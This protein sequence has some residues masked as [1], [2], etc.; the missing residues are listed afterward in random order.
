MAAPV[1]AIRDAVLF[2][3]AYLRV[4]VGRESS[5]RLVQETLWKSFHASLEAA[6]IAPVHVGVFTEHA[7]TLGA[8]GTLA[9][10]VQLQRARTFRKNAHEYE[11]SMLLHGLSRI[12]IAETHQ[13]APFI[14][15]TLDKVD[16]TY[17]TNGDVRPLRDLIK[18]VTATFAVS[19]RMQLP[20]LSDDD[21]RALA[22]ISAWIDML[23]AHV[24][25]SLQQ[26]QALLDE[27]D[28]GTRLDLLVAM[29]QGANSNSRALTLFR[30]TPASPTSLTNAREDNNHSGNDEDGDEMDGLAKKLAAL[31]ASL[32]PATAKVLSREL[33]RLK[34]MSPQQPEYHVIQN[35][36]EF[37]L[38]LPW[39]SPPPPAL[40]M[41]TVQ[42]TLDA[43]HY[44]MTKAKTRLVE[45]MAV[46]Q[47]QDAGKGLILCLV[48]PP[49]V[50]KTSLAQSM[51]TATGRPL[52]RLALGGVADETEVRGH[53]KTYVGA[54]PGSLLSALRRAQSAHALVV[55]DE[56]DKLSS[57]TAS[58]SSV[59]H[60]LLEVLDPHQNHAFT[61]HYAN[62]PFDLSRILFVA[63][64]N[65]VETIPRPLLDRMEVLHLDGYTLEEK[66]AI[67]T[68]YIWPRQLTQHG[69]TD[70]AF[71]L[72]DD[73]LSFVI[74]SH[75]REAGVRDLERKMGA[76]CRHLAVLV[77]QQQPLPS[78]LSIDFVSGILGPDTVHDEVALRTGVHGVAT[79]LAWTP[80]GGA[81][82][83]V[84]AT[85]LPRTSSSS[86]ASSIG[87]QLTGALGDVMKESAQLALTWLRVYLESST[88]LRSIGEFHIHF[89]H[90]ATPK[91]G[92]SAGIAIVS[93]LVSVVT[94]RLVPVDM[95]MTGEIT[96]RGV[97][98]PV[99]GVPQKLQ[100][101]K[102]AG[103][104]RV[105]LPAANRADGDEW[106]P[107]LG[108]A[109]T[110][111]SDLD[112][113]L[114]TVFGLPRATALS[115]R[116]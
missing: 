98:L 47:L 35:Y 57:R 112:D 49:G 76:I 50:G 106:G 3:G 104:A 69:L 6:A 114:A 93:A 4:S 16:D 56:I 87:L 96:L 28:I 60:A 67:A 14:L 97:V 8:T 74:Q 36:L 53:R 48:G 107:K 40:D 71:A 88:A 73:V 86:S 85:A 23:S 75:T 44:G 46:R 33:A 79:G 89:P 12:R 27:A 54:M 66:V 64:A 70:K 113:V 72:D 29:A 1:L 65:S 31:D 10:V 91:D 52:A 37:M 20:R 19:K 39:T 38:D 95:A 43:D 24:Q 45:F 90:G 82:L 109:I 116:L 25:G 13:T 61:D 81:I 58:T 111:V 7:D 22:K 63:T 34:R 5:L 30:K 99:G 94:K 102:R 59:S 100:A 110:Y 103:I 9:R 77:V 101:A 41:A 78:S 84:E 32:A 51:A 21:D 115:S 15:A 105:L 26:K 2:P 83:F 68:T 42:A 80:S 108:L 92:P 18:H 55:L 11:Y 17:D 62:V